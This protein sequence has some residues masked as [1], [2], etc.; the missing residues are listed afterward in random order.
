MD[1]QLVI[2]LVISIIGA[3]VAFVYVLNI[4]R[5]F[6][7]GHKPPKRQPGVIYPP[8]RP[9]STAAEH[10][11]VMARYNQHLLETQLAAQAQL[12]LK[13]QTTTVVKEPAWLNE[14]RERPWLG[15]YLHPG[16]ENG[17][18]WVGRKI[19]RWPVD[20]CIWFMTVSFAGSLDIWGLISLRVMSLAVMASGMMFFLSRFI[21]KMGSK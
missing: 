5:D 1:L 8:R 17:L 10:R 18:R 19:N 16:W 21:A 12:D 9:G 7:V 20:L 14:G 2:S 4:N 13:H 6:D 15:G 11:E 3:V